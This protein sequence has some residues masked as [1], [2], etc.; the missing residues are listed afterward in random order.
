MARQPFFPVFARNKGGTIE[1][2]IQ[3]L[4]KLPEFETII[5]RCLMAWPVVQAELALCLG[6]LLGIVSEATLAVFQTLRRSTA[7]RSAVWAAA[8]HG[9]LDKQGQEL[10]A[11]MLDVHRSIE[12][13]RVALAHGHFGFYEKTP[14]IILWTTTINYVQLKAKVHLANV[15]QTP[16]MKA[17]LIKQIQFYRKE[18]LEEVHQSIV[19][20]GQMWVDAINWLRSYPPR[21][22]E[23]YRQLCDQPR[24]RQALENIRRKNNPSAQPLSQPPIDDEID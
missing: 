22:D 20:C 14:D 11:A 19:Y 16:E 24:I 18:D 3:V 10:V 23:L 13:E 7:Q 8:S 12:K 1:L 2:G 4:G 15:V 5:G 6:Q 21:R 17:E 9:G